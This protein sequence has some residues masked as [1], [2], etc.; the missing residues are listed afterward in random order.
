MGATFTIRQ[1]TLDDIPVI[2][3]HRRKMFE[4]MEMGTRDVLDA[5]E[6]RLAPWLHER[7]ESERYLAWLAVTAE[8]KVASGAGVWLIDWPPH[9]IGQTAYRGYILNVYTEA[10]YRRQGLG[11]LLTQCC[12]DW[13]WANGVEVAILHASDQGRPIYEAMGFTPTNEMRLMKPS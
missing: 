1:A 3:T 6:K 7:M 2:V 12:L 13:C 11:R 5:M 4:D 10:E 9:V 8:G